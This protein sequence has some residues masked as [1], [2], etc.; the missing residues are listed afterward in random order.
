MLRL[1]QIFRFIMNI[2]CLI[3]ICYYLNRISFNP[4]IK[5]KLQR[6]LSDIKYLLIWTKIHDII[7][8]GQKNFIE[9]GCSKFNCYFTRNKELLGNIRT[10]DG[11]IFN[12]QDVSEGIQ[13]LP[14]ERSYNQK[15]IFAAND[16]ADNYPI[17]DAVYENFFNWTWTYK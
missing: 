4:I 6:H 15:Y 9:K 13:S 2:M 8:N 16:S 1:S 14:R 5:K 7:E 12:L 11:I 17:C 10:F 3:F